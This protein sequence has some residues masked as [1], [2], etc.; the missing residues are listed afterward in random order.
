MRFGNRITSASSMKLASW[1]SNDV[2]EL[3]DVKEL[4]DVN[5]LNDFNDVSELNHLS[6]SAY[7]SR[8]PP[9]IR[10]RSSRTARHLRAAYALRHEVIW[11]SPASARKHHHRR[12]WR[13][14]KLYPSLRHSRHRHRMPLLM[15]RWKKLKPNL[16]LRARGQP[17]K[18]TISIVPSTTNP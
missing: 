15:A 12:L 7:P 3:S 1:Y 16:P 17:R 11:S 14:D 10:E 5:E 13:Q 4:S 8:A 6:D 9:R 2:S 18:R